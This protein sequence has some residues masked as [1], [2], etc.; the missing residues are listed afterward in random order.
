MVIYLV[1]WDLQDWNV[2]HLLVSPHMFFVILME[3]QNLKNL[4]ENVLNLLSWMLGI[5]QF[6]QCFQEMEK[7][8]Y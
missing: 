1:L 6:F 5:V 2:T 3:E 4:M 8:V 7:S